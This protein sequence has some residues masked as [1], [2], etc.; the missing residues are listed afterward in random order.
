M[1]GFGQFHGN[2]K[3]SERM[4]ID[5]LNKVIDLTMKMS[6]RACKLFEAGDLTSDYQ[7][8]LDEL[9]LLRVRLNKPELYVL[10]GGEVKVG[11]STFTNCIIGKDICPMA[12]E[13]CTNVP[14]MIRFGEHERALVHYWPDEKGN[15]QEANEITLEQIPLYATESKNSRNK[16]S[17]D[18]IEIFVNSA[19][20]ATGL[21]FIDTPGLGA[22]DPKHAVATFD[23][24]SQADVI[25]FLGNTDKEL[26][27]FEIASLKQ[28]MECSK[29]G[30]VA[31]ILT[32][33]DRGDADAIYA[34]NVNALKTAIPD[35]EISTIRISSTIYKKYLV[36]GNEIYLKKSGYDAVFSFIHRIGDIQKD[37]LCEICAKELLIRVKE[38]WG[39]INVIKE[40]AEDPRKLERR[41]KEL[42]DCKKRLL[43][44]SEKSTDWKNSFEK[45]QL[46]LQSEI[47]LYITESE[48]KLY[49]EIDLLVEDDIYLDSKEMLTSA[50][51]AKLAVFKNKLDEH[52]KSRMLVIYSS[53]KEE[54]GFAK[55]QEEIHTSNIEISDLQLPSNCGEI[56]KFSTLRTYVGNTMLG[57]AV[58]AALGGFG[59]VLG[60]PAVSAKIGAMLGSVAPGLG[61]L[62]GAAGGFIL[63]GLVALLLTPFQT[64]EAKRKRIAADCKKQLSTF[65]SG[66]KAKVGAALNDNRFML[67][68]QFAQ[69]L[70]EQQRDCTARIR[71][72]Q[73]M[74]SSARSHW[75]EVF[76]I[77]KTLMSIDTILSAK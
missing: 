16:E 65:F 43:E 32:C 21:V 33:C 28:L 30:F 74:A 10:V 39:K 73:P 11:K 13:V 51:Q 55:V 50:I 41:L 57:G 63:G 66:V 62:I 1:G 45:K 20:L 35:Q 9:L 76:D 17:V 67:S 53:I 27:S 31:H 52:I 59:T 56:S 7:R 40:T 8:I 64:K 25:L 47:S 5:Q 75:N 4:E 48:V 72:L 54:T 36:N 68:T 29:C 38:L 12:D 34:Q 19:I 70:Q 23:M 22:L 3:V 2:N 37:I 49:T 24:A 69:E 71:K 14:S 58:G 6:D 42:E 18:Y 61:N 15:V 77:H 26:S 44:L 60:L 46:N